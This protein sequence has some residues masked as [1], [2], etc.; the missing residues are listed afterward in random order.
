MGLY[1]DLSNWSNT[2]SRVQ[3][4]PI[5]IHCC[6]SFAFYFKLPSSNI[7]RYPVHVVCVKNSLLLNHLFVYFYQFINMLENSDQ[8][9]A[10][11]TCT[12]PVNI[13][14]VK[15]CKCACLSNVTLTLIDSFVIIIRCS[16]VFFYTYNVL[17]SYLLY[18]VAAK[19]SQ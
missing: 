1:G 19:N 7:I 8:N 6:V 11:V 10:I 18:T 4:D 5:Q 17:F 15:Y 3:C 14:V 16:K 9:L 12:A 2:N 13:A